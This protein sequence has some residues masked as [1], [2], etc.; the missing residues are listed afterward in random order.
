M[1]Y[2]F[3]L[4]LVRLKSD[5]YTTFGRLLYDSGVTKG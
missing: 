1:F 5:F 2:D 3:Y 4:T